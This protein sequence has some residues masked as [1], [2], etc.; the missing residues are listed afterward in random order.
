MTLGPLVGLQREM[1]TVR[2]S[3]RTGQGRR[4]ARTDVMEVAGALPAYLM[5]APLNSAT[6]ERL[7]FSSSNNANP[8]SL[9]VSICI[10]RK[11]YHLLVQTRLYTREQLVAHVM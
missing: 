11:R 8:M 7:V 4:A 2:V 1:I 10:N 5:F 3:Q 9:E 6:P